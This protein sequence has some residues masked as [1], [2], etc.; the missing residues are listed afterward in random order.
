MPKEFKDKISFGI[1]NGRI[2]SDCRDTYYWLMLRD[3]PVANEFLEKMDVAEKA[4]EKGKKEAEI[5]RTAMIGKME[6]GEPDEIKKDAQL[7]IKSWWKKMF[8]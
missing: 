8:K 1:H 5:A 6:W 3:E 2:V 4:F 7:V